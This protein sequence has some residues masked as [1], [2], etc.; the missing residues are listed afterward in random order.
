MVTAQERVRGR[1]VTARSTA[2]PPRGHPGCSC[3]GRAPGHLVAWV[4]VGSGFTGACGSHGSMD[5]LENVDKWEALGADGDSHH[6]CLF[7]RTNCSD[8]IVV[9]I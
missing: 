6:F 2:W 9:L 8:Q 4:E 3:S 5:E 7:E 1:Q